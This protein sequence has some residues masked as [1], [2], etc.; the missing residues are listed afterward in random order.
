MMR[1]ILHGVARPDRWVWL[2]AAAGVALRLVHWLRCPS[3]WHDEAALIINVLG[4]DFAGMFGRLLHHEAAPPLF[5][6][7]ERAV[8]LLLGDGE[9]ALR[10]LPLLA[11]CVA[12]V[13]IA[14]LARRV[15]AAPAATLAVGLFAVSDRLLWHACEAK[16][17]ATD[18]LVAVLAAYGLVLGERAA[19][20]VRYLLAAAAAPVLLWLSFPACFVF[21]GLL[22]AWLPGAWQSRWPD[23]AAFA[24]FAAAV[25]VSFVALAVGPAAAQRD[26]TM[27]SCWVRQFPDWS[28]PWWVP[29]WSLFSTLEV[30]RYAL[31]PLGQVLVGLA[32]VGAAGMWRSGRRELV[33]LLLVPVGLGFVASCLHKYPYGGV[34][35]MAYAAPATILL[36]AAG[37]PAVLGWL[38]ARSR[39]AAVALVVLLLLPAAQTAFRLAVPWPRADCAGAAEYVLRHHRP[40]DGVTHNHWEYEYYFR[41][42]PPDGE[43]A[44]SP[45]T[46]TRGTRTWVVV[47]HAGQ[48][49]AERASFGRIPGCV[50]LDQKDFRFTTVV[51]CGP[52]GERAIARD[53]RGS[54]SAAASVR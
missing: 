49:P 43:A 46:G 3:V 42:L 2:F 7:A 14:D 11:S 6:V 32:V 41:R 29:F 47:T 35:V 12:V 8:M 45:W 30:G 10:F 19:P 31:Y 23:R 27:E 16:P 48:S 36:A 51:L 1:T 33:T 17:Y 4:N 39:A 13:L 37:T 25:G 26:G 9:Y 52:E 40:G 22:V 28:R 44:P 18:V 20:W 53:D 24:V 21:G 15:L 5:L 50:V 54:T 34:R 38:R